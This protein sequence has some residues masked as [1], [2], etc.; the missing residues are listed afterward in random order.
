MNR[1]SVAIAISL[2]ALLVSVLH[3]QNRKATAELE[4]ILKAGNQSSWQQ[5]CE[6]IIICIVL[7]S[8]SYL[9]P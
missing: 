9:L 2:F 4:N 8:S 7:S 6:T 1:F 3:V 5:I